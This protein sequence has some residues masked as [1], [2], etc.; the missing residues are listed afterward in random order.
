MISNPDQVEG[1]AAMKNHQWEN[2]SSAKVSQIFY[3]FCFM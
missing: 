2:E 3:I 1:K